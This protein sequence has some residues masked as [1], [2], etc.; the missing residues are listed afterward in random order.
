MTSAL[1]LRRV[2][3]VAVAVVACWPLAAQKRATA[4]A[5]T[6]VLL[7]ELRGTVNSQV[8]DVNDFNVIV[9]TMWDAADVGTAVAWVPS[10]SGWRIDVL[11][12]GQHPA[13]PFPAAI[14]NLGEILL[15]RA[16]GLDRRASVRMTNGEEFVLPIPVVAF[17]ATST[18]AVAIDNNG[19]VLG[20]ARSRPDPATET[21]MSQ[22][23]VWV[24]NGD[25]WSAVLLDKF[26]YNNGT[27]S[28]RCEYTDISRQGGWIA[29]DM[30]REAS[31]GWWGLAAR[32]IIDAAGTVGEF[33]PI[34][35]DASI[36]SDPA[37]PP[38]SAAFVVNARGECA[39]YFM[40]CAPGSNE[41]TSQPAFWD[42]GSNMTLLRTNQPFVNQVAARANGIND[43]GD[44]VG[45]AT[46]T[47]GATQEKAAAWWRDKAQPPVKLGF[48]KP[49]QTAEATAINNKGLAAGTA[50][51]SS[52]R[53][54]AIAW[55]LK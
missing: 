28:V 17:N 10:G 26:C 46:F 40:E 50:R 5:P 24:R 52:G 12:F 38:L 19:M 47:K 29:G 18:S 43:A 1:S 22:P 32:A 39:G 21:S 3:A 54:H 9:G 31:N 53:P 23:V 41:C 45:W 27:A 2:L 51:E 14:N 4:S 44:V 15:N 42:D 36:L 6:P 49:Y 16:D 35:N 37:A 8:S 20:S 30:A 13:G 55:R 33:L 25:E 7:P 11:D 48:P 34:G